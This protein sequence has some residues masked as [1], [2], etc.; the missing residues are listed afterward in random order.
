MGGKPRSIP[1]AK[2]VQI[3]CVKCDKANPLQRV[4]YVGGVNPD[5]TCWRLSEDAAIAGI[6]EGKWRFWAAGEKKSVWIVTAKSAGGHEYLKAEP[7]WV[8]PATLL[9]L[10]EC[11]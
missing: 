6:K 10:P 11:P 5:G 3:Q 8:Q 9:A 1:M 2:L 4:R 7:D